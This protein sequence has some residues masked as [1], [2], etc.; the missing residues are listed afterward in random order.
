MNKVYQEIVDKDNGDCWPAVIASLLD[1]ELKQ[2]PHFNMY[3]GRWWSVYHDFLK[4]H[5]YREIETLYNECASIMNWKPRYPSVS[6]KY[7][8]HALKDYKGIDGYFYAT[9]HSPKY[10]KL[11][12]MHYLH[13]VVI[14]HDFNIV[15]DPNFG[16]RNIESYPLSNVIGYNGITRVEIIEKIK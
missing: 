10:S 14:D 7:S 5:G 13:A 9:V 12:G 16:Y 3:N 2:V 11:H 4:Q 8:F 1:L 6:K 15:H